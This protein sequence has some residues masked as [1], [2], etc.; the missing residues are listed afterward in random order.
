MRECSKV[1][2]LTKKEIKKSDILFFF[3]RF[4]KLGWDENFSAPPQMFMH[5]CRI[6]FISEN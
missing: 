3:V 1:L 6:C 2:G 5:M 4:W